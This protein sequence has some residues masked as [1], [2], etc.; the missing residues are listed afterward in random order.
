MKKLVFD[1]YNDGFEIFDLIL[2]KLHL[3]DF[4]ILK[5]KFSMKVSKRIAEEIEKKKI[6]VSS[7]FLN[8]KN[9]KKLN[10]K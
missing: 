5:R 4:I 1:P 10:L 6:S 7:I 8:C 3:E 9:A 2:K